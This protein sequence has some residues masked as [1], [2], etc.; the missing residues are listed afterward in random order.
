MPTSIAHR[1]TVTSGGKIQAGAVVRTPIV[2]PG[3]TS[4]R[5][6]QSIAQR[7]A[8]PKP[9]PLTYRMISGTAPLYGCLYWT[10]RDD[11]SRGQGGI[12]MVEARRLLEG[13]VDTHVH[14]SPDLVA[15]K[16]DDYDVARQARERGMA[17]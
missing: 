4:R 16:L 10:G 15:R 6:R 11:G 9:W 17:A 2:R 14:S 12:G 5:A 3:A 7:T 8:W 13:A 1:S